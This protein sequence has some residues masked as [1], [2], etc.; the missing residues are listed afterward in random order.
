MTS[1]IS[2]CDKLHCLD[3]TI[4]GI[5]IAAMVSTTK[6]IALEENLGPIAHNEA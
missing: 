3:G 1:V 4:A 5:L 2:R 6:R